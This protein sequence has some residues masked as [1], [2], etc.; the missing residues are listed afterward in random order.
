MKLAI[1]QEYYCKIY[2]DYKIS[3]PVYIRKLLSMSP[4]EEVVFK[5]TKDNRVILNTVS[6]EISEIQQDVKRFFKNKP[7]VDD[8]LANRHDDYDD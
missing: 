5:I 4:N 8:F 7:I 2:K 1:P 3:I 6:R